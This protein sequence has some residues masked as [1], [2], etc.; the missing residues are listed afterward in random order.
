MSVDKGL[1]SLF[2]WKDDNPCMLTCRNQPSS[3]KNPQW[4]IK[5]QFESIFQRAF[6]TMNKT[7]LSLNS[8]I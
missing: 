5:F 1:P 3:S 2:V 8:S 6:L 4:S 7:N